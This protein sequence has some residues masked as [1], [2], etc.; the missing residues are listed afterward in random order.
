MPPIPQGQASKPKPGRKNPLSGSSPET[1]DRMLMGLC[2]II[3]LAFIGVLVG[4]VVV[5]AGVGEGSEPGT[6]RSWGIYIVIGV[7]VAVILGAI[8]LLLRARKAPLKPKATNGS[9]PAKK[10]EA[11]V[12]QGPLPAEAAT[13]K[14]RTFGSSADP[15]SKMKPIPS[16]YAGPGS[17]AYRAARVAAARTVVVERVWRRGIIVLAGAIGL[18]LLGVA[19]G[20]YL[21]AIDS[22]TAAVVAFV[23]AGVVTLAMGAIPWFFIKRL[24]GLSEKKEKQESATATPAK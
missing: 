5:M 17:P 4:A 23:F 24:R 6:G 22:P 10:A 2:G 12:P 13:E 14:L 15:V 7:S 19:T 1:I 3:W 8:P 11:V 16:D 20:T 18:A 21:L 9:R